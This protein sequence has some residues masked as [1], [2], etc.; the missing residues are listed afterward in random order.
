MTMQRLKQELWKFTKELGRAVRRSSWWTVK[1]Y[2]QTLSLIVG[3]FYLWAS[4]HVPP[5]HLLS[6]PDFRAVV[7]RVFNQFMSAIYAGGCS[8]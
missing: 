1:A 5:G 7:V 8:Q 6:G 3:S 2:A 4:Y